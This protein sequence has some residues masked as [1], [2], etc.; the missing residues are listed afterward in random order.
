MTQVRE[1][2]R[3]IN[4]STGG[5]D[6]AAGASPRSGHAK[7][8]Q[9]TPPSPRPAQITLMGVP[10]DGF[11][12][13]GLVAHL[14]AESRQRPG[15]YLMTPNLDNMRTLTQD[16]AVLARAIAADI[17]VADGMPLIWASRLQGTPLPE[18][19]AGSDVIWELAGELARTGKS[20]FL[21]GGKP[22]TAGRAAAAL[23]ARFPGLIVAGTYCPPVGFEDDPSEIAR[24]D[25]ALRAASPDFVYIGLPFP[26]A[27]A[28]ALQMR[29]VMPATW[30]VGLGISFSF[31][32]GDV[33]R[34]PA[35]M[36]RTGLE[37]IHR[38]AQEPRRL[39]RRYLLEGLPFVAR[40]L[41]SAFSQRRNPA[42]PADPH[43]RA[44]A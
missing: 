41:A 8:S 24:M 5:H 36:Q 11:T 34:A 42:E 21:L 4:P 33:R 28:L 26:K 38:L 27:S 39:A 6:R 43:L 12:L 15:G 13:R 44:P 30:F 25:G 7:R 19:V 31:V 2:Q 16:P 29:D 3:S 22:G 23:I 20:L 35:W 17:R 37:W 32:C 40:M 10:I 18:R 1:G 14:V 9:V